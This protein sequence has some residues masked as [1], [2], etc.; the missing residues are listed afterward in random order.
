[1]SEPEDTNILS[2]WSRRK[3]AAREPEAKPVP[4]QPRETQEEEAE[5]L[6]ARDAELQTNREAAEAIDLEKFDD[7]TDFSVF[8]KEGVPELLRRQAMAV[9]WRSHPVYANLDG[10]IDYAEDYGSP[11][12]IMKTFVSGWQSGRGYLKD[13]IV[14]AAPADVAEAAETG[15][16]VAAADGDPG[17]EKTEEDEA[18]MA[19][20]ADEQASG[21]PPDAEAAIPA[22]TM[23]DEAAALDPEAEPAPRVSLRRR[24][25][26]DGEG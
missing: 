24:L 15:A 6:T 14:G 8:M 9:L 16:P 4:D 21:T 2:R 10:L 1:M 7:T 12:L 3:L 5:R 17:D 23:P 19:A 26:L 22:Q 13:I 25:M 18:V 20:S 11:D